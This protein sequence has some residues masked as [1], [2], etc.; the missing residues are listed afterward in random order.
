MNQLKEFIT[1]YLFILSQPKVER[2][3]KLVPETETTKK[4]TTKMEREGIIRNVLAFREE[5]PKCDRKNHFKVK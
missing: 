1:F 2:A 3:I 4:A 5:M